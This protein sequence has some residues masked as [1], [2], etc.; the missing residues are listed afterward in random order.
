LVFWRI[1]KLLGSWKWAFLGMCFVGM[2]RGSYFYSITM[3]PEAPM[4]LGIVISIFYATDYLRR[5]QFHFLFCMS[6]G[7]ALAIS[8]KLQALIL[9][10]WAVTIGLLGLYIGRIKDTYKIFFWSI[11]SLITLICGI[12]LLTPYQIFHFQRL[13]NGIQVE[14]TRQAKG[15]YTNTEVTFFDWINYTVSNE[16][17]GYSYSLL[18]VL[19]LISFI[20]QFLKNRR[21]FKEWIVTPLPAL[22]L[23]NI[24]WVIIGAG[25]VFISTEKLISRYLIHVAPSLMLINFIG[26][27][28]LYSTPKKL[29][30]YF[31][32]FI[33]FLFVATGLQQ[34]TKH[35][36]FDFKVRKRISKKF[37][38]IRKVIDDT[39][40]IVP[41][42]S[43]ILNPLGLQID[44]QWFVNVHH[45]QPTKK[46]INQSNIEY[47]LIPEN[48]P[49]SLKR[50]GVS[51]ERS[52]NSLD[53]IEK[54]NFWESLVENGINGQFR[55]LK[56]FPKAKIKLYIRNSDNQ[57]K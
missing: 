11:G 40:K 49:D 47:L 44:T 6:L 50:E 45:Q 25:Y 19:T 23:T 31:W 54:I 27:Y 30:H 36:S 2:Q 5:P 15:G 14:L 22:F 55:I 8:S 20:K 56:Q 33:L 3:H 21:N 39:K 38:D 46:I 32:V 35:G 28:W 52:K 16:I 41:K 34:Q 9:L 10:P 48:Y 24:I 1:S 26:V 4:L 18:L 43:L 7:S 51:L 13:W 42:E 37:D 29:F 17:L 53:Y 57:S 12:L